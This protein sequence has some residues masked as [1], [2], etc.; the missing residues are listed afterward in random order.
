MKFLDFFCNSRNLAISLLFIAQKAV[1]AQIIVKIMGEMMPIEKQYNFTDFLII[2]YYLDFL[3]KYNQKCH[4]KHMSDPRNGSVNY[5]DL[6][7]VLSV[8]VTN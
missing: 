8:L 6:F 2:F 3:S 1:K 5:F 7:I 4:E